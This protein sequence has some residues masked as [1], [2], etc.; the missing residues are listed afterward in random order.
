MIVPTR[1]KRCGQ[2]YTLFKPVRDTTAPVKIQA[3]PYLE[4]HPGTGF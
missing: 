1:I 2:K 4:I 3:D